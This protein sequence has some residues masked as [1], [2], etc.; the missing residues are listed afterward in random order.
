MNK[1]ERRLLAWLDGE[2]KAHLADGHSYAPHPFNKALEYCQYCGET[3][4]V[5]READ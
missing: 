2:R 1:E 3:R 5:K 4:E